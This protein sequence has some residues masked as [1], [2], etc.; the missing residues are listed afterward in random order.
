[1]RLLIIRLSA[2]GDVAMAVP[3]IASLAAQYPDLEITVLSKPFA[4]PLFARMPANVRF[5][6]FDTRRSKGVKGV[7]RLFGELHKEGYDAVADLHD[8][9]RTKL[10][11]LLFRLTGTRAVHID[12]G[13]KAKKALTATGQRKVL[14]QLDSSFVRYANVLRQAGFPVELSFRSIFETGEAGGSSTPAA[15]HCPQGETAATPCI[16]FA[17]FA[18]HRGKMLPAATCTEVISRLAAHESWQ[19]RLFG[20]RQEADTLEQ[21]AAPY[22]NVTSLA[23]KFR[24]EEE[25]EQISRLDVMVSMDSANMHLASLTGTPVVSVWGATHPFAGFMGWGQS[26]DNAVQVDLPCRPCSIFG[27]KPCQRGD[28]ACLTGI[29]V[30]TIVQQVEKIIEA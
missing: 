7:L 8:V 12:K 16:G 9:L 13:R 6:A 30:T 25:L 20:S 28:Y 10:L 23:G 22:P 5:H 29:E 18:A 24:M 17:P 27:N 15:K 14:R 26:P 2:L 19:I 11:R 21:W 1:M 4:A 3:V